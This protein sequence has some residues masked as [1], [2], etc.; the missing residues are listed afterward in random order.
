MDGL[1]NEKEEV[2]LLEHK[3]DRQNQ[4][5]STPALN[6]IILKKE[7]VSHAH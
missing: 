2:L 1:P 7:R 3:D 6:I 4:Q 5:I